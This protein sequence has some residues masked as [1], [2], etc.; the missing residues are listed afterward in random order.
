MSVSLSSLD[1]D[2]STNEIVCLTLSVALFCLYHVFY[3]WVVVFKEGAVTLGKNLHF[4]REWTRTL[5]LRAEVEP[6]LAIQTFRNNNMASS[7]L[8]ST[9]IIVGF[10]I[11]NIAID[12]GNELDDNSILRMA[13]LSIL[14]FIAF[15]FFSLS[16]R[17]Y[18]HS[19]FLA[20]IQP[21]AEGWGKTSSRLGK[22]KKWNHHNNNH[23]LETDLT[24]RTSSTTTSSQQVEANTSNVNEDDKKDALGRAITLKGKKKWELHY[25]VLKHQMTAAAVYWT[26]GLR[27][28]YFAIPIGFWSVGPFWMLGTCFIVLLIVLLQDFVIA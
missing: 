21:P 7:F 10:G 4:R 11:L 9:S 25:S 16:I 27:G 20:G 14:F 6:I 23:H 3:F 8:A 13:I 19:A 26:L 24:K 18:N 28:F 12:P 5:A 22:F 17:S 1:L 2:L 15:F